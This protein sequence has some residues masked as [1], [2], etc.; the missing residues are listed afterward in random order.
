M[1]RYLRT[2][3]YALPLALA[4]LA[5]PLLCPTG[6]ASAQVKSGEVP[7]LILYGRDPVMRSYSF[8]QR[9]FGASMED[10]TVKELPRDIIFESFAVGE[11]VVASG[12]PRLGAIIDIGASQDLG[13]RYGYQEPVGTG[14]LGFASIRRT[15]DGKFEIIKNARDG[16]TQKL[17]EGEKLMSAPTTAQRATVELGHIYLMRIHDGEKKTDLIVKMMVIAYHKEDTVAIRWQAL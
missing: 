15:A 16:S 5:A 4:A 14:G 2:V 10:Y 9:A 3:L 6:P 7:F 17:E 13:E 8:S 11:L 1:P 12:G